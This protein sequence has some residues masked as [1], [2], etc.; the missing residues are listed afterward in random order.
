MQ[1]LSQTPQAETAPAR[2][3]LD[4]RRLL[5]M[6]PAAAYSTDAEGFIVHFNQRAVKAWGREPILNDPR[7]RY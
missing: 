2:S 6:L 1:V 7:D 4:F 3:D 5:E